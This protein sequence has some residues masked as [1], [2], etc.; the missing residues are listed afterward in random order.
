MENPRQVTFVRLQRRHLPALGRWLGEPHVAR[1]W[2]HDPSPEAV[3]KHFGPSVEG[4]EAGKDFVIELDGRPI[5]LIQLSRFVDYPDYAAEMAPFHP[6]GDGV[7]T[8]DYLIGEPGLVG[9]GLGSA[10]IDA[11]VDKVWDDEGDVTSIVVAVNSA[12]EASWRALLNAG[13][14]QVGQGEMD[15][16]NPIDGRSHEILRRT[17]P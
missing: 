8:I 13:F 10:V 6:V 17:R 7:A 1:W 9:R 12:N 14:S 4:V 2:N 5:G 3:E 16:D 15:P 11:F